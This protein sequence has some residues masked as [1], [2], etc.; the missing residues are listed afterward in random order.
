MRPDDADPAWAQVQAHLRDAE[1][2]PHLSLPTGPVLLTGYS[3]G[4]V[5]AP[6]VIAQLP[7]DARRRLALLT[8]ACPA[9]RL[10][11]RAF[12]GYFGSRQI[13]TLGDLLSTQDPDPSNRRW[14]NLVRRTD[15][16][17]S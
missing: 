17:G 2:A 15:Y 6:A 7:E 3:Q 1:L 11:G 12:P 14:K 4:A 5:I 16:I 13:D 8:L 10:Y 9:R